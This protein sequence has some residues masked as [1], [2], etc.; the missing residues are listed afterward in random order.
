M[1]T[2]DMRVDFFGSCC[3]QGSQVNASCSV[4]VTTI[5]PFYDAD[6]VGSS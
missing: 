2:V 1:W 3:M 6:E 5:D 4:V